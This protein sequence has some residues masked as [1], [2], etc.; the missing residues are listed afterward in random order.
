MNILVLNSGSSSIKFALFSR[1]GDG[2]PSVLCRGEIEGIAGGVQRFFVAD[3]GGRPLKDSN[4]TVRQT[5]SGAL[6]ELLDWLAQQPGFGRLAAIGHRVVHGGETFV[7]PTRIDAG[8]LKQLAALIPLAPL[9][10]P[11]NLAAIHAL[12]ARNPEVPQVACFDTAFHHSQPSLAR[13]YALPADLTAAGIVRYGFHGLSY[14]YIAAA[15]PAISGSRRGRVIVAHLG[16]GAS[17]CAL[18]DGRSQATSMGFTALDG[19]PMGTRCG[20]L[21][22]GVVLYL[23]EHRQ[24]TAAEIGDL[25]YHQ[26][27]LLGV[28]GISNDMRVLLASDD[29]RAARAVDLFVYRV[30]RELGSLTAAL[31][32]LDGLV[33]TGG[34]GEHSAAIRARVCTAAAWLGVQLDTAANDRHAATISSADSKV[35]VWVIPTDEER[36]IARET[37]ALLDGG[38]G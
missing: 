22:P 28:S 1:S 13:Q 27:G 8:V 23:Q 25:L 37:C 2:E 4:S 32:G 30:G 34:I 9:H 24:M 29:P 26:S 11:H 7:A 5:H 36:V 21:D 15:L 33:F 19:L 18:R 35:S 17:M 6:A 3:A 12:A 10:Q 31:G 38:A 14:S 16:N 20:S